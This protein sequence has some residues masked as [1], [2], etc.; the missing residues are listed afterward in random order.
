[1]IPFDFLIG[2]WLT[3]K[4]GVKSGLRPAVLQATAVGSA[5]FAS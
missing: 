2:P 3:W 5:S 1:M 4:I